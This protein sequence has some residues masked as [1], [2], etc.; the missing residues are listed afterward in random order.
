M[1]GWKTAHRP[2]PGFRQ[3]VPYRSD[4]YE[5]SHLRG[6]QHAIAN[7]RRSEHRLDDLAAASHG[8]ASLEKLFDTFATSAGAGFHADVVQLPEYQPERSRSMQRAARGL[9]EYLSG[10]SYVSEGL[11]YHAG[12]AIL[13]PPGCAVVPEDASVSYD[14]ADDY[15]SRGHGDRSGLVTKV[16]GGS[17]DFGALAIFFRRPREFRLAEQRLDAR[18]GRLSSAGVNQVGAHQGAELRQELRRQSGDGHN[19]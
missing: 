11:L 14:W 19:H 8:S 6:H 9:P 15:L 2:S 3:G 16:T 7:S 18:I 17:R 1:P 12:K 5:R 4:S 10:R 13:D